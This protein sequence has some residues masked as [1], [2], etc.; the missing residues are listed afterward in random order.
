MFFSVDT[1][2]AIFRWL[3]DRLE[4]AANKHEVMAMAAADVIQGLLEKQAKHQAEMERARK[5]AANIK[6]LIAH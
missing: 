1:L 6:D 2:L 3:I 5:V 4:G